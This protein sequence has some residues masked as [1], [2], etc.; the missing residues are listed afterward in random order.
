MIVNKGSFYAAK[1]FGLTQTGMWPYL[2][3]IAGTGTPTSDSAEQ[4]TGSRVFSAQ[5]SAPL[6]LVLSGSFFYALAEF[7]KQI[8][9]FFKRDW[10]TECVKSNAG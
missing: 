6:G 2:S 4:T 8:W 3:T 9:T 7:P 5:S 1:K 10:G